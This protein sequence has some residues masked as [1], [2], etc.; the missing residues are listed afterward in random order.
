ML[1]QLP[2]D[3]EDTGR[4]ME[5]DVSTTKTIIM[6]IVATKKKING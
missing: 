6:M 3:D 1:Q 2:P 5:G 4:L